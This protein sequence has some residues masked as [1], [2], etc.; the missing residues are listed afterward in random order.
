MLLTAGYGAALPE[1]FLAALVEGARLHTGGMLDLALDIRLHPWGWHALY[2]GQAFLNALREAGVA[3]HARW[4]GRLG[5]QA[6]ESGGPMR[7]ADPQALDKLADILVGGDNVLIICGC[8]HVESC[9]RRMVATLLAEC[10]PE[11][12]VIDLPPVPPAPRAKK[13]GDSAVLT[14]V[15]SAPT[16]TVEQQPNKESNMS[17]KDEYLRG[18]CPDCG[19]PISNEANAGDECAN[20]GHVFTPTNDEPSLENDYRRWQAEQ[21][22]WLSIQEEDIVWR[23]FAA[24]YR[25]AVNSQPARDSFPEEANHIFGDA[26]AVGFK[27]AKASAVESD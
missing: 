16:L 21:P 6:K 15:E 24:G 27:M 20:C 17:I 4:A 13:S 26:Y 8:A 12:R 5:N 2:R 1:S 14:A 18:E 3:H 9:H 25:A 10:L 11:L 19:D 22:V 7:L 23:G